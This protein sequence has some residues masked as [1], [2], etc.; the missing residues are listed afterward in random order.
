MPLVLMAHI[1]D[2]RVCAPNG[3]QMTYSPDY[4]FVPLRTIPGFQ[5][6]G[7]QVPRGRATVVVEIMRIQRWASVRPKGANVSRTPRYTVHLL[8]EDVIGNGSLVLRAL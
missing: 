6:P 5:I 1:V 3:G 2:N 7:T 4:A 8:S